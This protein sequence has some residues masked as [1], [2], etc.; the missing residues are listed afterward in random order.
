MHCAELDSEDWLLLVRKSRTNVGKVRASCKAANRS[1]V[2]IST[3]AGFL[4]T[5]KEH[6][7]SGVC[8]PHTK[9]RE[10]SYGLSWYHA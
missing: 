6:V 7:S 8:T 10:I 5:G 2:S 9:D 3:V 1:G 4:G